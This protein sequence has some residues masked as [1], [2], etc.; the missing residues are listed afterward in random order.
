MLR[1]RVRHSRGP[2]AAGGSAGGERAIWEGTRLGGNVVFKVTCILRVIQVGVVR[3][4]V[5]VDVLPVDTSKPRVHLAV[6]C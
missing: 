3:R 1:P 2:K 4:R 6:R 5:F